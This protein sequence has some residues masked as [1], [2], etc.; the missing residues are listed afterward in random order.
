[1][2]LLTQASLVI[3]PNGYKEGTLYSVIP[4]DGSGDMSVVRA[5]T[6][7]RVNS[8]GLVE[9]VPYNLMSYSEE[10]SNAYWT[11]GNVTVTSNSTISPN[12]TLTADT[13]TDT[14]SGGYTLAASANVSAEGAII[15]FSQYAKYLNNDLIYLGAA[16]AGA[17]PYGEVV[18]FYN[19][20]TGVTGINTTYGTANFISSNIEN[21]GNGWYRCSMTI[22]VPLATAYVVYTANG[23]TNGVPFLSDIGDASYQWG[24]QINEGTLKDYQKTETR[25]NIPRLDYS[26]GTCPSLLVE[27]QRTNLFTYSSSFDNAAWIKNGVTVTANDTTAPDGTLTADKLVFSGA[28]KFIYQQT[29]TSGQCS[30]SIYIKGTAGQT[31][32]LD[33]TWALD[34]AN[35]FT[36]NGQWQRFDFTTT[37]SSGQGQGLAISTFQSATA[38]TIWVWGAQ[39]E[40]GTYPTSYIPTTSASVTRNADVVSK[41]GISSLIGQTEGTVFFDGIAD[42]TN[43]NGAILIYL[44]SS[45]GSGAFDYSTYLKFSGNNLNLTVYSGGVNYVNS[46]STQTYTNK[47]NIKV[48]F[49]Y[50]NNDFVCYANGVQLFTDTTGVVSTNLSSIALGFYPPNIPFNQYNGNINASALWKTRLTN[51]QLAQL[52]TI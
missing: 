33:D 3:T 10:Y 44:G 38:T 30:H 47:Q 34:P 48:A 26:N 42:I 23:K 7:T 27:P 39:L 41:T 11:K 4:S 16:R 21:V 22:S 32:S 51:T 2:S 50:K 43:P 17:T 35:V 45:D 28:G 40:A 46:T 9:L 52:T 8:A 14:S 25:L 5:T 29:A 20:N 6:A 13:L 18:C 1:M 12:G 24:S 15:T 36:L 31:I 19:I 37:T 49:S